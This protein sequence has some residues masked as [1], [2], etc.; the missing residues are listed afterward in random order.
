MKNSIKNIINEYGNESVL[1]VLKG[2]DLEE[3]GYE[4]ICLA[5][6]LKNK[7]GRLMALSAESKN[8][9]AFDEFLSIRQLAAEL[10]NKVV[11]IENPL[12]L[13]MFPVGVSLDSDMVNSLLAHY[14][15]E[16]D[17]E[18]YVGDINNY[19][20]I[21][22]NF[23]MTESGVAC[24][25]NIE[26]EELKH[27][28]I[29]IRE[30]ENIQ[31]EELNVAAQGAEY[32]KCNLYS[33]ADY[34]ELV[35]ALKKTDD[36]YLVNYD[37]YGGG[38][39]YVLS[40]L[41]KLNVYYSHRIVKS[42]GFEREKAESYPEIREIMKK[43]WGY[44]EYR[45]FR[46]YDV[47]SLEKGEKKVI[48]V[49]Q[50]N[51]ISDI[52]TQVEKCRNGQ[53]SRDIFVTAPTGAGKSL[54]FQLPAMYMAEK[55]GLLTIV[56]TPLIGLMNDQVQSL[57]NKG[58]YA[59]RTINSDISPIVKNEILEDVASGKCDI[60]YLSPESLLSKSDITQL[61]GSRRIGML[62]VDEAHIVTTWGKQFRPDYWYLGD[63]VNRLRKA[64]G[65][66]EEDPMSFVIATFTATAI[67]KGKEDMYNETL[68]SLHMIDPVTYLGYIKRDNISI[69]VS[70]TKK[71][72]EREE[73][74]KNKFDSLIKMI[75]GA[76]MRNRKVLI[77]FPTVALIDRFYS[78]CLVKNLK[79]Y[80]A[81][82]HGR[83]DAGSKN[84]NFNDF[85]SGKK[86]VM[87][88]TKAFGMGI[89][90]PDISIVSH[91]APTGNVC[92][93]MQEIGRAARDTGIEGHAV[94]EHMSNDFKHINNLH[95]LSSIRKWQLVEV[96][97]K[98]LEL[99]NSHRYEDGRSV[100]VKKRNE[101]LIDTE[102]FA[103][104]FDGNFADENNLVNK[105]K[106]AMLLIQKDYENKGFTPFR[107]RPIPVFAYGYLALKLVEREKLEKAYPGCMQLI[108]SK[109]NICKV[110]LKA[111]WER[112]YQHAMS[113]PK[114]KYL[115]Y[116]GS[117]DLDFNR[118]FKFVTAMSIDI[119]LKGNYEAQF[120]KIFQGLKNAINHSV[121][122]EVYMSE[123]D[124][125]DRFMKEVKVNRYKAENIV[126]VFIAAMET[127]K[128]N[129][130][131]KLNAKIRS[132]QVLKNGKV[133]YKFE[134][135]SRN[136]IS[137]IH[138]GYREVKE[139]II[140]G[141]MYVTNEKNK[142]R[143]KEILTILGVLESFDI[144][145]FKSLGGTNSQIYI[146]VN[147]TK[148]MEMV[149]EK[150]LSYKNRLLESIGERHE[151]SVKIMNYLF[152]NGFKSDEIWEYLENYFLGM[153]PEES[154]DFY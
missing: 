147:E 110:N 114:F 124:I 102:C 123:S 135:A 5:D 53:A 16:A 82:Y 24:C 65:K 103:Y 132:V 38:T 12:Y 42:G 1:F 18:T 17:A 86:L 77:Y 133:Q 120:E 143:T 27:G 127:Y 68:N 3:Y 30:A 142:N 45:D 73:Y 118:K 88:A 80:V 136:F 87:I 94:Y 125:V 72:N 101:M 48:S 63:H 122:N 106:T 89:D 121:C 119:S 153:F 50:E 149:A 66:A 145:N 56:I 43:Y 14:D 37:S 109:M 60:L 25:F 35:N 47:Y 9:I 13:N 100:G 70:Q 36:T 22:S 49:S 138:A 33:D 104:I 15:D 131:Y 76:V 111:I 40:A 84:E 52:V 71:I 98:V 54:M 95:G 126:K 151:E 67:Y 140:D 23:I 137:W 21:Y 10:F 97:K 55:Y 26:D 113:F 91:F 46:A 20:S 28:N 96:I 32:K 130:S 141:C 6:T 39:E 92:D 129:Y 83:M 150:P 115:L 134:P 8:V 85:L 105:V 78:Y 62:V 152:Q 41:K 19:L 61:I 146:Y 7:M 144:L 59:A 81:K 117:E 69:E 57:N 44:S 51:V 108:N 139:E 154:S 74:E 107:M 2:F 64:Q 29:F 128:K 31:S 112:N 93:Y 34:Y 79:D 148:T 116:S 99:Y 90:I 11:I 75:N 4:K 58:Y